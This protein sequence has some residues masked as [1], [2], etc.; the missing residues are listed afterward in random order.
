[1][2]ISEGAISES[3][4]SAD[5]VAG[6]PPPT[7]VWGFTDDRPGV[8]RLRAF[9]YAAPQDLILL[10]A[11]PVVVPY[12]F[13]DDRSLLPRPRPFHRLEQHQDFLAP[14]IVLPFPR[15]FTDDYRSLPH[16]RP[17]H[18]IEQ[19]QDPFAPVFV[20]PP[21]PFPWGGV[22]DDSRSLPRPRP[23]HRLEQHDD[24]LLGWLLAPV[25]AGVHSSQ[26]VLETFGPQA[27]GEVNVSQVI[28]ETL[29]AGNGDADQVRASQVILEVLATIPP[30]AQIAI[31]NELRF[32]PAVS[33]GA[34]GGSSG[35]MTT[36]V[37]TDD[38]REYRL[39]KW[40]RS[41]GQWVVG[42]N[43]RRAVDWQILLALHRLSQGRFLPIRFQ[44]W[45][46]YTVVAGEGTTILNSAGQV[47]LAK[48]YSLVDE[49]SSVVYTNTRPIYKP[50]L[51]SLTFASPS[52]G[53][54]VNYSTGVISG[55]GV[56]AGTTTWTGMFD[57]AVRFDTDDVEFSVDKPGDVSTGIA[58]FAGGWRSIRL[59]EVRPQT[60]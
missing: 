13:T 34:Y 20:A 56:A 40:G 18:R 19:H 55:P 5:P 54:I 30:A 22:T 6:S 26:I 7:A 38:G 11:A 42:H 31:G 29:A 9:H 57:V 17:F 10:V 32:P 23:F 21:V 14:L 60:P 12:G 33:Y 53:V 2:S 49:I 1:M 3:P 59:V 24:P 43:L 46:D 25:N 36:V 16:P 51:G 48:V 47:Q 8:P 15:G 52:S 41:L 28:L 45:T 44:D 50:Q 58:S 27:S 37:S 39:G 35:W 4:I